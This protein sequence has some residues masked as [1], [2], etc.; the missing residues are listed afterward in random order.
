MVG[1][2]DEARDLRL[3]LGVSGSLSVLL[4]VVR[5][6]F[7]FF[8]NGSW[9]L[10]AC[11]ADRFCWLRSCIGCCAVR[12]MHF[13]PTALL[14]A[15]GLLLRIPLACIIYCDFARVATNITMTV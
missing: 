11:S 7:R 4:S 8:E 6:G 13:Y 5:W 2:G 14:F 15:P 3:S 1:R 9:G 12:V 10:G